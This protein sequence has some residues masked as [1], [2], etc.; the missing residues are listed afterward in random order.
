MKKLLI[1]LLLGL[2][3]ISCTEHKE[4]QVTNR[5]A[6]HIIINGKKY[7]FVEIVPADGERPVWLLVPEDAEIEMPRV[8]SQSWTESCGKGCSRTV[9]R[10]SIWVEA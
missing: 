3:M 7:R 10:N 9:V 6:N 8:I 2:V 1:V 4:G 5:S